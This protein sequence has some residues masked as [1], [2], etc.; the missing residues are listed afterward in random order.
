LD[1]VAER[2][3]ND[4]MNSHPIK[5]K[6]FL[7]ALV[8]I[9]MLMGRNELTAQENMAPTRV[10]VC[11]YGGTSAGIMAAAQAHKMGCSVLLIS[12]TT[13]LGGLTSSGLGFTDVGNPRILGGMAHE[14][15]HRLWQHYQQDSAWTFQPRHQFANKGQG[16]PALNDKLQIALSF[17][18][19]VA[20]GVFQE[21]I[22]EN[23]IQVVHARL[24]LKGGA[25]KDGTRLTGLRAENGRV[26][27]A[28]VFIDATYE[29]DL[30]AQA[31]VGFTVGREANAQYGES[32][33]GI[34][35]A[36]AR[37]NQ[38]P[39]G[40][41]P[42]ITKGR[43][44]SGLLP[45]IN[46]NAGGEDGSG[47]KRIQA[48]C[49]RMCLTD[50]PEN[51][52]TVEKPDGYKD[53]DYELLFRAIELM[54]KP[55][56]LKLSLLPNRKTDSNNQGG[57][58][59]DSIGMNDDYPSADYAT[60]TRIDQSHKQWQ[61]GLLWTLQNHPRVPQNIRTF[62]Q[63]WG[64]AKDEFTDTGHWPPQLYI[65]EARRMVSDYVITEALIRD[66]SSVQHSIGM[67]SYTLDSHNVQRYM[68]ASGHVRNE[69]DI[70]SPIKNPYE[71]DYG[72]IVPRAKECENLL[73]PVCVSASHIAYGS[74][75]MEPVFMILG[76]SA[77]T[78]AALAI[79]GHVP[80]Q[81]V[82]YEKLKAR[83][84]ADGQVLK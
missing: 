9:L 29:G 20:E 82:D 7:A 38:L 71:I 35:A 26:Y 2:F 39:E 51:R 3:E 81:Q 28:D 22:D 68:D 18:P 36:K 25:I 64:L 5:W 80:V 83:L 45:G 73:V 70:Q 69:G 60:R 66:G 19:H 58:S 33:D 49:Y 53:S 76:Q 78:A 11:V 14:Y 61:M 10:E 16:G 46:P 17:E 50:V 42:Y 52:V 77:G 23:Q 79:E 63:P 32:N 13:H 48:Y 44:T 8:G 30:M 72:S 41:D 75:R 21:F 57:I 59:T 34:Q 84:T 12:P 6:G 74:I 40:I 55:V 31:G 37:G 43:P 47:D 15:F 62:Y 27:Q 56:F 24:D 65:R 1:R 4:P 54:P 67:G